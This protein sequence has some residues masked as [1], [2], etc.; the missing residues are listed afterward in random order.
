MRNF[1]P[2]SVEV[3]CVSGDAQL[4][5]ELIQLLRKLRLRGEAAHSTSQALQMIN[6]RTPSLVIVD[7]ILADGSGLEFIRQLRLTRFAA[8][9]PVL[10][11][12]TNFQAEHYRTHHNGP[13]PQDWLYKPIDEE[14]LGNAVMQ[15]VGVE[16]KEAF[17]PEH[18]DPDPGRLLTEQGTFRELPF[19]RVL[20]LAGR[21]GVGCLAIRQREQW[22]QI[23]LAGDRL[24]GLASSYI[25]DSSLG[26]LLLQSGRINHQILADAQAAMAGGKRFGEWLIEHEWL[27]RDEL[28]EHLEKQVMEKLTALFS[29]RWYDSAWQ[30]EAGDCAAA[31]HVRTEI[32]IRRIIFTGITKYYDR[33]RLEMIFMKRDRLW[34]PVIPTTPY[35]D[36]V[37]VPARRL[38]A[39][40]DGHA[41][42]ATVRTRAG[43][44]ISRFYQMLYGLWILDLV[45]FG[46]PIKSSQPPNA[47]RSTAE[48]EEPLEFI[49]RN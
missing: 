19:A 27:G 47:D 46:E 42:P 1:P 45:R 7:F 9:I 34:R 20:V 10:M 33:D 30:Y 12:A 14:R 18:H 16:V 26:R 35:V 2:T 48:K 4:S 3:L 40:A 43:M 31:M 15:W 22:L 36:E 49:R 44:E 17:V 28:N 5:E 29:W 32:P 24:T 25:S 38:L 23:G 41:I 8:R 21:R 13:G 37:P 39:A 11:L 6:R